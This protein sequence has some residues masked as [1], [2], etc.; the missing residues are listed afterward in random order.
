MII[1][2]NLTTLNID[3]ENSSCSE[4]MGPLEQFRKRIQAQQQQKEQKND[5]IEIEIQ[6]NKSDEVTEKSE[7]AKV[8]FMDEVLAQNELGETI[9]ITEMLSKKRDQQNSPSESYLIC[10]QIINDLVKNIKVKPDKL[11]I[12]Q[13]NEALPTSITESKPPSSPSFAKKLKHVGP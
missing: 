2:S 4:D 11:S 5:Q 6:E 1:K 8:E 12:L 10:T 7:E 13:F 3:G 9:N